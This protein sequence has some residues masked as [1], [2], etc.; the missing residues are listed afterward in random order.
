MVQRAMNDR[1]NDR[2]LMERQSETEW[3]DVPE[4]V[5]IE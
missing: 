2:V 5:W 1:R 4:T 3:L